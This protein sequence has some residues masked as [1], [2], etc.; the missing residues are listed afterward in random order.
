LYPFL[1]SKFT[2]LS[3][4]LPIAQYTLDYSRTFAVNNVIGGVVDFVDD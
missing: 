3:Y 2:L 4:R 1:P